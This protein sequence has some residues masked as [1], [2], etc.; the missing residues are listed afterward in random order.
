MAC[1]SSKREGRETWTRITANDLRLASETCVKFLASLVAAGRRREQVRVD[2]LR[3]IITAIFSNQTSSAMGTTEAFSTSLLPAMP[4]SGMSSHTASDRQSAT[5]GSTFSQ[6]FQ[7]ACAGQSEDGVN[8]S[9]GAAAQANSN[10]SSGLVRSEMAM[11]TPELMNGFSVDYSSFSQSQQMP[12]MGYAH[13]QGSTMGS[14][15]LDDIQQIWDD[16]VFDLT[17]MISGGSST[18]FADDMAHFSAAR[19]AE[20]SRKR[21]RTDAS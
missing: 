8:S 11:P 14:Q 20:S 1:G 17:S 12:S 18:A 15:S 21:I 10:D 9:G 2:N 3:E 16:P 5:P 13:D 6:L 4:Q 19:D 7:P